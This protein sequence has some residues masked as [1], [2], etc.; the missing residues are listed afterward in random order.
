MK[1]E[2]EILAEKDGVVET[3]KVK[4]GESVLQ[5]DILIELI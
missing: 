1:M 5:G 2:N 4:P 3:I